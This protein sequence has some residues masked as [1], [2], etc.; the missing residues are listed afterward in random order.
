VTAARRV[1][2]VTGGAVRVGRAIVEGLA[3][4]GWTVAFTYRHSAGP[5]AEL[6]LNL[7]RAG[8]EVAVL[9][10]D[11]DDEEQRDLLI[12]GVIARL[13]R[14]DALV[15]NAAVFPRTPIG[16]LDAAALR[17]A[18]RTNLESPLLLAL[19]AAPHL[20]EAGGGIVN[21][22]DIWGLRP[23]KNHLAYSVAKAGLIA[24]T[25]AL[26]LELAP[27]VRV[28]AVAPGIAMFPEEYDAATRKR[29]LARTLLGREGGAGEV[30]G[31]V[32]YLLEGST[33]VTGH[34]LVL[35]GE[36]EA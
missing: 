17:G 26:A 14:L 13:G 6:A 35:G 15:N 8:H 9:P 19:A 10:C 28:N 36:M 34:V 29:L 7:A 21:I 2:L 23:L 1:A 11:L 24:A 25:R 33:T 18:L 16:T 32:R 22:A 12:P 20:A 31:A 27:E 4:A 5:A 3:E 30:A